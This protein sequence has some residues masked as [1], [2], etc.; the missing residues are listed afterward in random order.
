[1][2][3]ITTAAFVAL[4]LA[5]SAGVTHAVPVVYTDRALFDA[6]LPGA[7]SVEDF[8]G[9]AAGTLIPDGGSLGGTIFNYP[10][11]AGFGI[12]LAVTDGNQFGGG[13]PFDTTSGANFLGTDDADILQGGDAIDL[14]LGAVNAI[15]MYFISSDVL[16]DADIELTA[17]GAT[18]S[19][20][21]SEIQL[22]L[23]DGSNVFFLGIIDTM[24]TFS[25]AS[26]TSSC[27][28]CYLFNI[29]DIVTTQ[30]PEPS[31]LLLFLTGLFPLLR[32]V[33][34]YA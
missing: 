30:V 22:T 3:K 24:D 15:G 17:S 2:K 27:A 13:G 11:L 8:E 16:F 18:A 19:L 34:A 23:A 31:M 20:D 4:A 7:A 10:V 6:D 21:V 9:T 28:G 12:S 5:M 14:G 32:K 1:M 33:K 29:D 25:T 26:I